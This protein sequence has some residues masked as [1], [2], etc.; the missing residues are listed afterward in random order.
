V[1][2]HDL[3][4]LPGKLRLDF[5]DFCNSIFVEDPYDCFGLNS[6]NLSGD[7]RDCS[8]LEIN[9]NNIS[10]RLVYR[11]SEKPAPK[12]VL[13]LSF[14]EHDLAYQKAKERKSH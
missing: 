1:I 5:Q 12:R 4:K 6:H 10:Y 3:P 7:L 8:A 11:I 9:W 13:I 2:T 14:G